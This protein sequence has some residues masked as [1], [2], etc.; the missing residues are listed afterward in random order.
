MGSTTPMRTLVVSDNADLRANLIALLQTAIETGSLHEAD[1]M[2]N[3]SSHCSNQGF[4]VMLLDAVMLQNATD[5]EA[6]LLRQNETG[7]HV[8]LVVKTYDDELVSR[9]LKFGVKGCVL[10]DAPVETFSKAMQTVHAGEMWFPRALL[11]SALA[12]LLNLGSKPT[13]D[14]TSHAGLTDRE[15][16]IVDLLS[17][18]LTNKDI[19]RQIGISDKTVKTHVQHILN[20]CSVSRRAQLFAKP[21]SV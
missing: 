14:P 12:R 4:E 10:S 8:L 3:A 6:L 18:G 1:S 2:A 19:A 11:M 9:A 7:P 15:R 21:R 16:E 13:T 17:C 20:K 5:V